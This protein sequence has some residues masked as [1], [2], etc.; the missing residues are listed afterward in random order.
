V[1][2]MSE[3]PEEMPDNETD[4]PLVTFACNQKEWIRKAVKGSAS[5]TYPPLQIILSDNYSSD[6]MYQIMRDLAAAYDGTHKMVLRK[7][8]SN[9]GIAGHVGASGDIGNGK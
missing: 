3:K 8:S 9:L 2:K 6:G 1:N 4:R 7:N 5:Q